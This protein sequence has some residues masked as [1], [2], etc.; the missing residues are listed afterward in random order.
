MVQPSVIPAQDSLIGDLLSMDLGAPAPV[1]SSAPQTS[2]IDLLGGGLDG[3]VN[4]T[5]SFFS[6]IILMPEK[7]IDTEM[8]IKSL[9][10]S[11]EEIQHRHPTRP[12]CWVTYLVCQLLRFT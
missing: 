5:F 12:S 3:L 4:K 6:T 1:P 11:S 2:A 10:F 8:F 7:K 9:R